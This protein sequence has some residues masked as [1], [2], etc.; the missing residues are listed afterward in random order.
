MSSATTPHF[1]FGVV[2]ERLGEV[3]VP[4][5]FALLMMEH[6]WEV[7]GVGRAGGGGVGGGAWYQCTVARRVRQTDDKTR[8]S[9]TSVGSEGERRV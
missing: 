2:S 9:A 5:T 3:P 6:V 8:R 1:V 7:L 4:A